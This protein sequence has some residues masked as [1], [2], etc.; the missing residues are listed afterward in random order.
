MLL[1]LSPVYRLRLLSSLLPNFYADRIFGDRWFSSDFKTSNFSG[2]EWSS[3]DCC[4][5]GSRTDK[6][7]LLPATR[8][9]PSSL[10]P[11]LPKVF[12]NYES[13]YSSLSLS[14]WSISLLFWIYSL[15]C[16]NFKFLCVP[17]YMLLALLPY[18]SDGIPVS[19]AGP[20][21][22]L[23]FLSSIMEMEFPRTPLMLLSSKMVLRPISCTRP[24]LTLGG[25]AWRWT[26][27]M[28]PNSWNSDVDFF[29]EG[30]SFYIALSSPI[31]SIYV[32][33]GNSLG[34]FGSL[35]LVLGV[36]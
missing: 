3:G 19:S 6:V 28:P 16:Y 20:G 12:S 21:P 31:K 9:M 18:I 2:V 8:L 11:P 32:W 17:I 1:M 13:I 36:L 26:S 25:E 29:A 33:A 15:I 7:L 22:P 30:P 14:F 27:E 23:A 34:D 4:S 5:W 24:L 10:R 35:F